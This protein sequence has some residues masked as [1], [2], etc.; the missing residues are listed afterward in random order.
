M[1]S[2]PLHTCR[3]IEHAFELL[4]KRWVGRLVDLLLQRP[5]RF[6]ELLAALPELSRRVLSQ[7][8]LELQQCGLVRREVDP[9]PPISAT[10]RLTERGQALA[11]A[12]S[13][14]RAWGR[15]VVD[16]DCGR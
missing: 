14:L 3:P 7:R 6:S 9:G 10:Y 13:A 12:M 11:P 8:L 1:T 4:G 16:D 15:A 5:A 2:S